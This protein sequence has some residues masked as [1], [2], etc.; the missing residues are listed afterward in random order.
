MLY[1]VTFS[2]SQLISC[3]ISSNTYI[4]MSI[5][6]KRL[7]GFVCENS[8]ASFINAQVLSIQVSGLIESLL[9]IRWYDTWN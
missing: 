1:L 4:S 2:I 6:S 9:C 8:N 7:L 5:S 3:I